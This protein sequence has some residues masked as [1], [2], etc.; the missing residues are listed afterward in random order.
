MCVTRELE[1]SF[2]PKERTMADSILIAFATRSGST[3]EVAEKIAATLRESGFTV[4][5]QPVKQVRTLDGYRAVVVGAPLYM[6]DW[7]KE[8]R[9]FLSRHRATL[10]SLPVAIFALG[11][12]ED[13]EKDWTETRKQF[14]QVLSQFPWLTP[15]AA[16]LFGGRFDPARL[17]FPYNLIPGLKRMPVNDIRDW[18]AIGAW[19][20]GLVEKLG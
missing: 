10:T 7:L 12:T 16:E 5:V 20:R 4:D 14:N 2:E 15:V 19:A 6:S 8:A 18:E 17:T 11:P 1:S 13:K 3:Q 9:D